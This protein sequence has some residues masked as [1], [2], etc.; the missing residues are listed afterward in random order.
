VVG[1]L[2]RDLRLAPLPPGA[3]LFQDG[4]TSVNFIRETTGGGGA[5]TA[6][7]AAALGA[8][9]AFLG[10]VGADPLGQRLEDALRRHGVE[11]YLARDPAAS[12]GTSI[13]LAYD[14]GRR[15]F[16]SCLANNES[17]SF[18]D[19]DLSVLPR[20]ELLARTDI[21]FS[22]S[23][24]YGGNLQ[25]FRAARAAGMAISIDLNW[26]PHW[27]VSPAGEIQRRKQAIR[28]VLP[29]VDLVHGNAP[30][31]N[32]VTG[33]S[34]L[35]ETLQR[36]VEWGARAIVVHLG[37][38][39]AGFFDG[40]SLIVEPACPASRHLNTTG[41]GDVLSV[42]MMLQH[43]SPEPVREKLRRANQIVAEYIAGARAFV[44]E[45]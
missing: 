11:P 40:N 10:K 39:G 31:L 7:A 37:A 42:C 17:L 33:C 23:M 44:P 3:Y 30:E 27:R 24:L 29:F 18:E 9:V 21:W 28:D 38:A 16:V 25:L 1:N 34:N 20:F 35:D 45:L 43:Q 5:N 41:T 26:D 32:E 12:T 8:R 19:L 36:I 13:N 15:H 4:E 2:N 6:C 14:T 22:E